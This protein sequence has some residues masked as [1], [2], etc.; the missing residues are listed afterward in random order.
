[1]FKSTFKFIGGAF[2][3]AVIAAS[4]GALM[5]VVGQA[6][7][8]SGFQMV[9]SAWLYGLAGGQ[10][11][12]YQSGIT[13]HAGGTQAAC[14]NLTP[15]FAMY[16]VD[17]AASLNDSICLPFAIAGTD[18]NLRNNGASAIAVYGQ[19][20]NNLATG[21]VDTINGTTASTEYPNGSGLLTQTS[22]E[23]FAVKNGAWSCVHG[24]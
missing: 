10:N 24:S 21:A 17:T 19:V 4:V 23:C 18:L 3:G 11:Y 13:A 2:F 12:S 20:N 14:Q 16:Q 7:L 1:M 6:P 5:A 8:P 15:G 22:M 9:D